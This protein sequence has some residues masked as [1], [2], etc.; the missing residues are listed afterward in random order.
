[1]ARHG[2]NE[3]IGTGSQHQFIVGDDLAISGMDLF[4]ISIDARGLVAEVYADAVLLEKPFLHHGQL[5]GCF[6]GKILGQVDTVVGGTRF[7][8]EGDNVV[9]V[10][11]IAIHQVLQERLT[12]HAVTDHN[13]RFFTHH[14]LHV[15]R[16]GRELR[17]GK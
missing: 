8:A 16:Y 10:L 2:G 12:D 7:L 6:A 5:F 14:N 17:K 4:A 11:G 15:Y 1:M 9:P 3:G 13:E